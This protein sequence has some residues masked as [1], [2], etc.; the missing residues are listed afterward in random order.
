MNTSLWKVI[1]VGL[2]AGSQKSPRPGLT[3]TRIEVGAGLQRL[4]HRLFPAERLDPQPELRRT[5]SPIPV[6][7][8]D[9]A[10]L[11]RLHHRDARLHF[12]L[13][14]HREDGT[15]ALTAAISPVPQDD[16]RRHQFCTISPF[17]R[18]VLPLSLRSCILRADPTISRQTRTQRN[19]V[20]LVHHRDEILLFLQIMATLHA[21][22]FSRLLVQVMLLV[23]E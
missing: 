14:I 2:Q 11:L 10:G 5:V 4:H 17:R 21:L 13:P 19:A 1:G 6:T 16:R 7:G 18:L 23:P 20:R 22:L 15:A 12:P 3:S 8:R 9:E